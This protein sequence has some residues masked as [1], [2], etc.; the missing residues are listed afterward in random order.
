VTYE[1]NTLCDFLDMSADW[2]LRGDNAAS[3]VVLRRVHELTPNR[4]LVLLQI[5]DIVKY[6]E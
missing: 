4:S 5:L 6:V 3:E 1:I 2:W